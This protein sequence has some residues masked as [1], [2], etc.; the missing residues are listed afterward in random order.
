M[1]VAFHL[2]PYPSRTA[3]SVRE[4]LMYLYTKYGHHS[5]LFRSQDRF[6]F[7]VYDSYH[8]QYYDWQEIL[9]SD[10]AYSVRNTSY[11]GLF[12]G[13]WLNRNDGQA[14]VKSGFD[15]AYSYFASA[16][17]IEFRIKYFLSDVFSS[18]FVVTTHR[19]FVWF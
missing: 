3:K 11:D 2:E 13:L 16:G 18:Y 9:T 4:D 12:I 7:Y 17:R 10:G 1:K 14:L 5:S 6:L 15:G 19:F 8:I